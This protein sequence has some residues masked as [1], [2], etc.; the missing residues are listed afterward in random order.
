MICRCETIDGSSC[1]QGS[2][3]SVLPSKRFSSPANHKHQDILGSRRRVTR[4]RVSAGVGI[5]D[6]GTRSYISGRVSESGGQEDP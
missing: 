2:G 1:T 3:I 5:L 4:H 6:P